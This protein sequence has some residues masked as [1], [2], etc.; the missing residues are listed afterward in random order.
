MRRIEPAVAATQGEP[1]RFRSG[2]GRCQAYA[3]G[4][5]PGAPLGGE[6]RI[7]T[8]PVK[9][10][11][12]LPMT[13]AG[14]GAVVA[15]S[16]RNAAELALGESQGSDITLL[17]K[18]DL[19]TPEGAQAAAQQALAEGAELIVGPLFA[20]SV[21]AAGQ[22]ARRARQSRHRLL[23]RCERRHARASIS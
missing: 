2:I 11:L 6:T 18:D 15:Q 5:P 13:G 3:A 1:A 9:V 14:Q 16:M 4:P 10:A 20:G 21:Q 23:V 12:I 17:V 8:G 22:V 19:G 7:G